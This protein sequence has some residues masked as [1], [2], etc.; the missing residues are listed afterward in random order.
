MPRSPRIDCKCNADNRRHDLAVPGD[1]LAVKRRLQQPPLAQPRLALGEEEALAQQWAQQPHAAALDE[2]AAPG[3]EQLLDR[4][5]MVDEQDAIGAEPGLND[6]AVL[7]RARLV[8][9]ELVA[10]D[11]R[12]AAAEITTLRAGERGCHPAATL[13]SA[14][15]VGHRPAFPAL[16]VH[17]ES[18]PSHRTIAPTGAA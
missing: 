15:G 18:R 14:S 11:R 7:P 8:E 12:R 6:V 17:V 16:A 3:H 13:A 2:V 9:A 4:V 5:R 1:A 10:P